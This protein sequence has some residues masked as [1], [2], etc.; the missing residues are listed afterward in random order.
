M[1]DKPLDAEPESA[2]AGLSSITKTFDILQR[3]LEEAKRALQVS[4]RAAIPIAAPAALT[5]ETLHFGESAAQAL[6]RLAKHIEDNS[7]SNQ[8]A[9]RTLA[10]EALRDSELLRESRKAQEALEKLYE[11]SLSNLQTSE[12]ALTRLTERSE[13][14]EERYHV[15]QFA[16]QALAKVHETTIDGLRASD[17][18]LQALAERAEEDIGNKVAS[19]LALKTISDL[20]ETSKADLQVSEAAIAAITNQAKEADAKL[21]L[22]E[23][24]RLALERLN[25]SSNASLRATDTALKALSEKV[26]EVETRLG[27][28]KLARDVLEKLLETNEEAK[29]VSRMTLKEIT[30]LAFYDPLTGLPNRRLLSERLSL[31]LIASKRQARWGA[32][33]FMDLDKFKRLN[34]RYGHLVGD[35]LLIAAGKR[36][37]DSVREVDTVARFGGDEFV[38]ILNEFSA[39]HVEA[40][41]QAE[42]IAEKVHANLTQPYTLKIV[43]GYGIEEKIEYQCLISI[44]VYMFSGDLASPELILDCAD[45][46]MYQAKQDGGNRTHFY[47]PIASSQTT[48][49]NL[50]SMATAHDIE[51]SSHG[52]AMQKY[53]EILAHRLQ[54]T[55]QCAGQLSDEVVDLIDRA[56][57]LHDIGKTKIPLDVLKKPGPLTAQEREVMKTHT[58]ISEAIL[59]D[60]R[61]RNV[62]LDQLLNMAIAIAGNHHEW[63]D[64][65]GYPRGT[66]GDQI[67]LA[68]RIV[69]VADVYDALV[70][71]RVYK[72]RWSHA[73]ATQE[74]SDGSGK[75]FDPMVVEAFL[76]DAEKFERINDKDARN[77]D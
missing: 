64:G 11:T 30:Q 27:G 17:A 16:H 62:N 66:K 61:K 46:A 34:D 8:A 32:V 43:S 24:T 53:V 39:D 56:T 69:A 48:L 71:P 29:Q 67:P 54:Q 14:A 10:E 28:S 33:L 42:A 36:L 47:D 55:G 49:R 77:Q 31:S 68:A 40:V 60:A 20:Y 50:Y 63:W 73:Q 19:D 59:S 7:Q 45:E 74:I 23:V 13:Q 58:I 9:L 41:K 75:Q 5:Q 72:S 3:Q 37:K 21:R 76:A 6:A 65:T 44:G 4:R 18:L 35:S 25:A 26:K 38:V 15:E 12:T 22:G 52:I 57:P 51:T 70:N 1:T 2:R